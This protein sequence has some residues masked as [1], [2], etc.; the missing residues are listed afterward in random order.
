MHKRVLTSP[1]HKQEAGTAEESWELVAEQTGWTIAD[2][3][4]HKLSFKKRDDPKIKLAAMT[5]HIRRL[6]AAGRHLSMLFE[7]YA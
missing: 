3:L 5:Q 4:S 7:K 6:R 2:C 1:A